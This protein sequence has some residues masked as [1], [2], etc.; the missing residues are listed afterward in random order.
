V[1]EQVRQWVAAHHD[2]TSFL[3]FLLVLIG[4][5]AIVRCCS[6]ELPIDDEDE[7]ARVRFIG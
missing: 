7:H 4:V 2:A 1:I 5:A 3:I 6:R